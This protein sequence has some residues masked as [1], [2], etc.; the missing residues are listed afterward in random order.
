M[1]Q[2]NIDFNIFE[3]I[4]KFNF[5]YYIEHFIPELSEKVLHQYLL[6]LN[7]EFRTDEERFSFYKALELYVIKHEIHD[8]NLILDIKKFCQGINLTLDVEFFKINKVI[9]VFSNKEFY[10]HFF[11]KKKNLFGK[12]KDIRSE[13]LILFGKT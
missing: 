2:E 7:N 4:D 11:K 6:K 10:H 13:S 5:S 8:Q 9:I 12:L 1:I 3:E